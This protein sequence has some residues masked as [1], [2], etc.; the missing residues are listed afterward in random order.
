[1]DS[2]EREIFNYLK[3][4]GSEFINAR[5]VSRRAG[6]KQRYHE[7]P[8]WAKPV[9]Q[10][11]QDRSIVESD[12]NGRYRIKPVKKDKH[13]RWVSPEISK[14]LGEGGVEGEGGEE[15]IGPDEHYEEL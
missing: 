5:E 6:S 7:D 15:S 3:T 10:R 2:D 11:M 1:M 8:D 13:K 4:W 14:I 9:L 12:M